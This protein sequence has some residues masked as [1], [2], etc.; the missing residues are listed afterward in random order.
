MKMKRADMTKA[1]GADVPPIGRFGPHMGG[2]NEH[3]VP[4]ALWNIAIPRMT[5][6]E[7]QA[8]EQAFAHHPDARS[9]FQSKQP[10]RT[11][12]K[13]L[14][15]IRAELADRGIVIT[16]F[17]ER[18]HKRGAPSQSPFAKYERRKIAR[19]K[20]EREARRALGPPEPHPNPPWLQ[21]PPATET[22]HE[23]EETK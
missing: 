21:K 17:P 5:T 22:K 12:L 6:E 18:A 23:T 19:L 11:L 16:D 8:A 20:A 2:P 9:W 1:P 14:A 7:L 13:I 15:T 10:S 3:E 4:R